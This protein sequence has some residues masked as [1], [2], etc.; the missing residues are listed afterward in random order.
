MP[1]GEN[2]LPISELAKTLKENKR[3]EPAEP[4][5][6]SVKRRLPSDADSLPLPD[7]EAAELPTQYGIHSPSSI[8]SDIPD[9]DAMDTIADACVPY[10]CV[11]NESPSVKE[12]SPLL[13]ECA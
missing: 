5:R 7:F 3:T 2:E 11:K 8:E 6:T 1:E 12:K 9:M 13:A 4:P 10:P